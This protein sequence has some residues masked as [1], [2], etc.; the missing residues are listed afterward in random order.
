M[1]CCSNHKS[2]Y[3]GLAVKEISEL[4]GKLVELN[5]DFK[6][7][8]TTFKCSQCDQIWVEKYNSNGHGDVASVF[9]SDKGEVNT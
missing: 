6:N 4:S 1:N 2:D 7:W 5:T 8:I 3:Q 9:K